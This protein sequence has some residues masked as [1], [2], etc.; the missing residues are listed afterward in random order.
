MSSKPYKTP[1]GKELHFADNVPD[2]LKD[3][4]TGAK[5]L[6]HEERDRAK[7]LDKMRPLRRALEGQKEGWNLW[8]QAYADRW[9][10]EEHNNTDII[11]RLA[12][13]GKE[14]NFHAPP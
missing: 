10:E 7:E 11:V 1:E 6:T 9:C 5:V 13:H 14:I 4:Y 2:L 3:I 8:L 12:S